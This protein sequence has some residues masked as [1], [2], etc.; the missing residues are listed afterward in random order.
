MNTCQTPLNINLL[1]PLCASMSRNVQGMHSLHH[2]TLQALLVYK[3]GHAQA[4]GHLACVASADCRAAHPPSMGFPDPS[5]TRPSMS[6][7]TG[8]FSTCS[9]HPGCLSIASTTVPAHWQQSQAELL[10]LHYSRLL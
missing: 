3:P 1:R 9:A 2:S 5:N 4:G 7:E 10:P 8:V 6:R